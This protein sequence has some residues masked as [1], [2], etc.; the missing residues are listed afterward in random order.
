MDLTDISTSASTI[1]SLHTVMGDSSAESSV[2]PPSSP[3][4]GTLPSPP[5]SP[6]SE[7]VS[8]MP[9][10]SSS[11]FFSSAAASPPHSQPHSDHARESTQG[12]II[13]SLTL[14]E[15]LHQPTPYGQ[16]LGDL[17]LLV[18][19]GKDFLAKLLLEDN[20]DIVDEG[21]WEDTGFGRILRASTDWIDHRDAHG[22]EKFEPSRNVEINEL[23]GYECNNN[24]NELVSYVKTIV[25]APFRALADV[26]DPSC[27][28]SG[29]AANLLSSPYTPLYTA[30]VL[31]MPSTPSHFERT[32]IDDLSSYIP[33]IALPRVPED[34]NDAT[35]SSF[36]P[37]SPIS[38]RQGLFRNPETLL[39]VRHEATDRFFRWREVSHLTEG[40]RQRRQ[41][42]DYV[43]APWT[44][45]DWGDCLSY[46]VAKLLKD[47]SG[48]DD[49]I[50]R[51]CYEAGFDPLH[52]T[53]VMMFT[54]SVIGP[55]RRSMKAFLCEWNVRVAIVGG[56]CIGLGMGLLF[57]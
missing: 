54:L 23:P 15:A 17:R 18:V 53:S 9:S 43:Q 19:G 27:D 6:S 21:Q 33:I 42:K 20:Q 2:S 11:F 26:L 1:R 52:F 48:P 10:V 50:P 7:S 44:E 57:R 41:R 24:P 37:S 51:P 39:N 13:P 38:L 25:Q 32:I 31:L 56:F 49:E 28:P 12:L 5:D 8:S 34:I 47:D 36:K 16:T 55:A 14:P 3:R 30:L 29:A 40:V 45:K 22:L 46:D 35:L 4:S